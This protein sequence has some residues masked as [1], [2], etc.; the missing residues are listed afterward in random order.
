[1]DDDDDDD[2]NRPYELKKFPEKKVSN[3]QSTIK[4]K[5]KASHSFFFFF[6]MKLQSGANI[7]NETDHWISYQNQCKVVFK[8]FL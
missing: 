4:Q 6:S 3:L 8:N 1:M 7:Q 2:D 5:R